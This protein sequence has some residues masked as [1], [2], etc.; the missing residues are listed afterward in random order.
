MWCSYKLHIFSQLPEQKY[1]GSIP[2]PGSN[3]NKIFYRIV[4]YFIIEQVQREICANLKELQYFLPQKI[5][6]KLLKIWVGDPG[7]K[8]APDSGYVSVT[9]DFRF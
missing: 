4:N 9:L 7:V 8:K 3:K 5:V 2:D 6:S 1:Y